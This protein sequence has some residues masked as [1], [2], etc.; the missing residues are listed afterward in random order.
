ML[1]NLHDLT[2]MYPHFAVLLVKDEEDAWNNIPD[3]GW[4][5]VVMTI[6]G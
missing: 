4:S 3:H 5:Y 2:T 1:P 6:W